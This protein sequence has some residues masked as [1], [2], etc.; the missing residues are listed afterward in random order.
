MANL[1][2]FQ[3]YVLQ[4]IMDEQTPAVGFFRDRYF[5]TGAADVFRADKVL[6]EYRSGDRKLAA[7]VAPRVGDISIDRE[8]Y[9]IHEYQP[10]YIGVSRIL[11]LDDLQKRGFGEAIYATASE[12]ERAARI[13]AKDLVDLENRITRREEW[14]A[15]QTMINNGCTMQEYIDAKTA[16]QELVVKF[17]DGAASDHLYT[18]SAKWATGTSNAYDDIKAMCRK[19]SS[20]G[21]PAADLVL[22][23]DAY[24][25]F[26]EDD[27]IKNMIDKRIGFNDAIINEELTKYDGVTY[28]GT[29][30]FGGFRLATF[31]SDETY[32]DAS[33]ATQSYFPAKSAMVTAPNCGHMMYGQVTQIDYN[34]TEFKSYANKRVP[35]TFIDQDKDIRKIRLASRPLAAPLQKSPYVYAPN[36]VA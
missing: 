36:V 12:Q 31:V 11:S 21:L 9:S 20:R 27:K 30:N 8:G 4:S 32:V 13:L 33:G 26:L 3:T 5:P 22:G 24:E 25:A 7:F 6:T 15:V 28:I 34:S 2:F 16:G 35:K 10:A 18:A 1:N 19:L 29:F 14:M 23:S 17:Y